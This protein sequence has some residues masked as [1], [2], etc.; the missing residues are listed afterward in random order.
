MM[1][2]AKNI[3]CGTLYLDILIKRVGN[4][5]ARGVDAFGTG[6]GYSTNILACEACMQKPG[7]GPNCLV[8]I[9]P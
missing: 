6:A 7:G 1:D 2:N 8:A 9:H 3:Q 4:D 5:I